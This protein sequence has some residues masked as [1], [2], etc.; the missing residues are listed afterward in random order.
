M[1][2]C[3][4][5]GRRVV[6][7]SVYKAREQGTGT[8]TAVRSDE[9]IGTESMATAFPVLPAAVLRIPLYQRTLSCNNKRDREARN[10]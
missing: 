5:P 10:L 1:S 8:V 3:K 7:H 4:G 9:S 6:Q 2:D